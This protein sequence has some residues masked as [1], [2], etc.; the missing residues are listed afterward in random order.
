[1]TEKK[2]IWESNIWL[3]KSPSKRWWRNRIH[4]IA[5]G[6]LLPQGTLYVTHRYTL[7]DRH[8]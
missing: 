5:I 4:A 1:V 2:K 7:L 3:H 8:C 6:E